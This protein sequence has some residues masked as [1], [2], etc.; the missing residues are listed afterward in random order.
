MG[1]KELRPITKIDKTDR[2]IVGRIEQVEG[3]IEDNLQMVSQFKE[4]SA[5][6]G[7]MGENNPFNITIEQLGTYLL[8][9]E[10]TSSCR[11]G[12]YPFYETEKDYRKVAIGKNSIATLF[13]E[14]EG[15]FQPDQDMGE[16]HDDFPDYDYF[17]SRLK[18]I[19]HMFGTE[20]ANLLKKSGKVEFLEGINPELYEAVKNAQN[21][22]LSRLT[23]DVDRQIVEMT[24]EGMSESEISEILGV[25]RQAVNKRFLKVCNDKVKK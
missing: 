17:C 7:T 10:D 18:N 2:S 19:D 16:S 13:G 23:D 20:I 4:R 15:E 1:F 12:E 11:D 14:G 22:V 6:K 25:S 9:S 21:E 3:L 5:N 8:R 24:I